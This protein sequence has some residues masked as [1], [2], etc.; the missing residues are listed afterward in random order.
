[1]LT[2][3]AEAKREIGRL[4]ERLA[5]LDD[6]EKRRVTANAGE[7]MTDIERWD[8]LPLDEQKRAL[9][10]L[11]SSIKVYNDRFVVAMV[12]NPTVAIVVPLRRLFGKGWT[13][14]DA[15]GWTRQRLTMAA[16]VDL[17]EW[18]PLPVKDE[19]KDE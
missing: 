3:T 4:T 11:V 5:K 14:V 15:D 8:S 13:P 7:A 1:M 12:L 9:Q 17:H 19:E 16:A 18:K 6:G 2:I 10:R